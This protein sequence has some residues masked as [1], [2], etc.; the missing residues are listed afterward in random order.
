MASDPLDGALA[1]R[2]GTAVAGAP[3]AVARPARRGA[4]VGAVDRMVQIF[5]HLQATG[6]PAT[7]YEIA[8][9][10][11]APVST[12]YA[13][14]EDLVEKGLLDRVGGALWLGPR[15]FHYGLGYARSL[16]LLTVATEE[17]HALCRAVGETVQVCGRDGDDMVVLAMADGPGAFRISSRVGTRVPL[18]WTASGRLL[19]GHL[20][21]GERLRLFR[22]ARPSPTGRA[23]TDPQRLS[24]AARQALDDALS[25]QCGESDF[26]VA[27]IAAPIRDRDGACRATISIVVP[28]AK[29][30]QPDPDLKQAVTDAAR[31]VEDRLGW[32]HDT[33]DG[34]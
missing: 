31:R 30:G 23:E 34:G 22:R 25:V 12:V 8:R 33:G 15:L 20:D 9:A 2:G 11:G 28:E 3:G 1:G 5:D 32:R 21:E 19:V 16:D 26:A 17:M 29:V 27:C 14:T 13:L 7:G 6:R 4:R 18:N 10:I 24:R